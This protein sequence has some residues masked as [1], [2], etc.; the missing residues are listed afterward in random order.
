MVNLGVHKGDFQV[1][2]EYYERSTPLTA[3]QKDF[4]CSLFRPITL[5]RRSFLLSPGQICHNH[6]IVKGGLKLYL[7]D[8][9]MRK[10]CQHFGFEHWWMGDMMSFLNE[11]PSRLYIQA[12]EST[13]VLEITLKNQ[14]RLLKSIPALNTL[15]RELVEKA[16]SRANQRVLDTIASKAEDRYADFLKTYPSYVDRITNQD[17]ASYIGVTPEF[18]SKM[19]R[20]YWKKS[21]S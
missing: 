9:N 11:S 16:L 19:K 12:F 18:F 10:H 3:E 6:F 14:K 4:I 5:K 1:L 17:I 8:E 13:T 2:I 20:E 15:Y 7:E 21:S